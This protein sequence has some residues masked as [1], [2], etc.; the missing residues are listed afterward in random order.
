[1]TEAE[2]LALEP[3][4]RDALV[5]TEVMGWH[6]YPAHLWGE[7]WQDGW[8]F[9]RPCEQCHEVWVEEKEEPATPCEPYISR[10]TT[11]I[12]DAWQVVEKMREDRNWS[13]EIHRWSNKEAGRENGLWASWFYPLVGSCAGCEAGDTA[14]LAICIAALKAKGEIE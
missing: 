3:R 12:A 2:F 9:H 11:S 5:A 8:P 14:P 1:M 7:L 10:Y 6:E 13:F 4:E